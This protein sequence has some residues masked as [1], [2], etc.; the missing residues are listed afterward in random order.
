MKKK[1]NLR[2]LVAIFAKK[3]NMATNCGDKLK[4]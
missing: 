3:L 4:Q 1:E 2:K